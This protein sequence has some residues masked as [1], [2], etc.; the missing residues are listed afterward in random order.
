M[1]Q[2]SLQAR[3]A[4]GPRNWNLGETRRK[5]RSAGR[6]RLITS[7]YHKVGQKV[8]KAFSLQQ[9]TEQI[10]EQ[11]SKQTNKQIEPEL[12]FEKQ[13]AAL[14]QRLEQKQEPDLIAL[15]MEDVGGKSYRRRSERGSEI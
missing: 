11:N 10:S 14:A 5:T 4:A 2:Q 13:A 6:T 1:L 7:F 3:S 9:T 8:D 12:Q 15:R